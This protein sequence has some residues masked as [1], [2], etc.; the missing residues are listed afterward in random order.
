MRNSSFLVSSRLLETF[1][2]DYLFRPEIVNST[3]LNVIKSVKIKEEA[4]YCHALA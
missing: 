2:L 3:N 4:K 1:T